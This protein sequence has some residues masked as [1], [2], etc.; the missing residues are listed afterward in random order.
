MGT[1]LGTSSYILASC[2]PSIKH[3][4]TIEN[5]DSPE[6]YHKPDATKEEHGKYIDK[7][8]TTFLTDGYENGIF[9]ELIDKHPNVI[10]FWE[11]FN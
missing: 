2:Y 3:S 10:V 5:I 7:E 6:Y 4:Y 8:F 1:Y 11:L 9:E